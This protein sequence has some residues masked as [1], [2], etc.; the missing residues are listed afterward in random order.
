MRKADGLLR[1]ALRQAQGSERLR[2]IVQLDAGMGSGPSAYSDPA[3]FGTRA[4]W[5]KARVAELKG[6]VAAATQLT[7]QAL[8][9]LQVVVLGGELSNTIVI[10]GTADQIAS[11]LELPGVT[12]AS[13]DRAVSVEFGRKDE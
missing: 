9:D 10:E 8:A 13:L 12:A 1:D 2:A 5:Q 3:Q 7:R 6:R 4:A 11:S